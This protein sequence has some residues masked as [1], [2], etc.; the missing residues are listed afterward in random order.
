M[1]G[2]NGGITLLFRLACI[3]NKE[4]KQAL[5]KDNY[6]YVCCVNINSNQPINETTTTPSA[7]PV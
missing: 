6:C 5:Q 7:C 2:G 4:R 1:Q 3:N